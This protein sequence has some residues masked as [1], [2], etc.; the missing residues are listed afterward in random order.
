VASVFVA[1]FTGCGIV[2]YLLSLIFESGGSTWWGGVVRRAA[3]RLGGKAGGSANTACCR[4][5]TAQ[6]SAAA[7]SGPKHPTPAGAARPLH[8]LMPAACIA[9]APP[10][11][12]PLCCA[13]LPTAPSC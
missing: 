5:Q 11:L 9:V 13:G 4:A 6:C 1:G 8:R 10:V 12:C 3:G 7:P 2:M